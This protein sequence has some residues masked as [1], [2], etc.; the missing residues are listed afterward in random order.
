MCDNLGWTLSDAVEQ[1]QCVYRCYCVKAGCLGYVMTSRYTAQREIDAGRSVTG[2][3]DY[4]EVL[5]P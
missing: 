1:D 3:I 4:R 5:W 2:G